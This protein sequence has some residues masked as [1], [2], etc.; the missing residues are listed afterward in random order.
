MAQFVDRR[1]AGRMLA[2]QLERYRDGSPFLVLGLPRGGVPVAVE[3]ARTLQANLDVLVV[4][5]VAV[6]SHPEVAMGVVAAVGNSI[7]TVQ[8][9]DVLAQLRDLGEDE[10]AFEEA[11]AHERVELAR[12]ERMYRLGRRPIEV[13]GRTVIL[14]DDGLA[15]GATMRAAAAAVR[16]REPTRLLVAVPAGS[17]EVCDQLAEVADDVVCATMPEPVTAVGQVYN[18]FRPITDDEVRQALADSP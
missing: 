10:E 13:S 11:A 5:K 16:Q 8:N 6:S 4:R 18:N 7:E 17:R 2:A 9:D 12:R 1:H 15:T 14:V 3:V